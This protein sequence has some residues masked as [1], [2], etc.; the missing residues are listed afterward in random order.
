MVS[1]GS[2]PY[3]AGIFFAA[4]QTALPCPARALATRPHECTQIK[5]LSHLSDS[6][7]HLGRVN[8]PPHNTWAI[9]WGHSGR[10][11]SGDLDH[12]VFLVEHIAGRIFVGS[13][14]LYS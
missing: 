12:G 2:C 7:K 5:T 13:L 3:N 14:Q 10:P 4:P 1:A 9:S 8:S 11:G 6:R